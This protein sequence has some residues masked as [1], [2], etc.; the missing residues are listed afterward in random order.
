MEEI[1]TNSI[2]DSIESS[3]AGR[4][5]MTSEARRT[6]IA[7]PLNGTLSRQVFL[8]SGRRRKKSKTYLIS[9][10]PFDITRANCIAKL[11]SNVIGTQFNT[12]RVSDKKIRYDHATIIYVINLLTII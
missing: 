12:I 6:T 2:V 3:E 11:K 9:C 4:N 10:D 7:G 8:L 5:R 1:T